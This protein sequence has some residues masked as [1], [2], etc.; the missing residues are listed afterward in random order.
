MK[1]GRAATIVEEVREAVAE[2]PAHAEAAGVDQGDI[3][4]IGSAHRQTLARR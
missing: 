4:R 2:W 1:R 3:A